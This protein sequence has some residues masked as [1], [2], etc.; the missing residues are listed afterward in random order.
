MILQEA[1]AQAQVQFAIRFKASDGGMMLYD[2]EKSL[3][4]LTQKY[5]KSISP[6]LAAK[7]EDWLPLHP[8][9]HSEYL[10]IWA[11]AKDGK[12]ETKVQGR[13]IFIMG[14]IL[15]KSEPESTPTVSPVTDTTM[16]AAGQVAE[17]LGIAIAKYADIDKPRADNALQELIW[18]AKGIS[19]Q[20]KENRHEYRSKWNN[21]KE[22][23]PSSGEPAGCG[24]AGQSP[25]DQPKLNPLDPDGEDERGD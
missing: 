17:A 4:S 20:T 12:V 21:G 22:A 3:W 5:F 14:P 16:K 7:Y 19:W 15:D 18:V 9:T 23:R 2:P 24:D 25:G 8:T 11:E 1:L 10:R 13:P 6:E